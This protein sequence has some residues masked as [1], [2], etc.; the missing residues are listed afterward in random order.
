MMNVTSLLTAY[1][2][3]LN[4]TSFLQEHHYDPANDTMT[5]YEDGLYMAELKNDNVTYGKSRTTH[6]LTNESMFYVPVKLDCV[7]YHCEMRRGNYV[8]RFR[9]WPW[10]RCKNQTVAP[11]TPVERDSDVH[12]YDTSCWLMVTVFA[13]STMGLMLGILYLTV[14]L[15]YR[16]YAKMVRTVSERS[17]LDYETY[18]SEMY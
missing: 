4:C 18:F 9:Q 8:N 1:A 11:P 14:P 3:V 16:R 12:R 15:C 6:L 2:V 10:G 13:V 5:W 7:I 17:L